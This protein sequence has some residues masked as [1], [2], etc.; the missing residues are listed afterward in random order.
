MAMIFRSVLILSV[1]LL[2]ACAEQPVDKKP[3]AASKTVTTTATPAAT[4]KSASSNVRLSEETGHSTDSS[5]YV[6]N[7]V[8]ASGGV[9]SGA[10]MGS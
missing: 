6:Q 9:V 8:L 4:P 7:R 5:Y 3:A 1:L 10:L 2:T